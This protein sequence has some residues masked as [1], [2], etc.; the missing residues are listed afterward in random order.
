[1]K[2]DKVCQR[3]FTLVEVLI[4]VIM[5]ALLS[6]IVAP[7]FADST[8]DATSSAAQASLS[9]LRAALD[10]YY[11]QHGE[12]PGAKTAVPTSVCRG[13]SG[14][15]V[16]IG[17]AG[18]AAAK[19]FLEQLVLY[20]DAEGGACSV[21]DSN[22]RFGPYIDTPQLENDPFKNRNSLEVIAAGDLH[23]S[24]TRGD[25][26]GYKYDSQTGKIIFNIVA[27]DDL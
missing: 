20:T 9:K 12:Y 19:T 21:S 23:I 7:R 11:L 16:P 8:K 6:V 25:P 2:P 24:A 17:G 22:H 4:L 1:M 15:G 14:T 26:G 3:G 5:L 27:A 13:I 10:L 18:A